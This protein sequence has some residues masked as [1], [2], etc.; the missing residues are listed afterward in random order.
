MWRTPAAHLIPDTNTSA[1]D[2]KNKEEFEFF[3]QRALASFSAGTNLD[4]NYI[5]LY[6]ILLR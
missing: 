6:N 5:E 4:D 2:L 3:M 1:M